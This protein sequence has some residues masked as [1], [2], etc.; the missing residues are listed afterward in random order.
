MTNPIDVADNPERLLSRRKFCNEIGISLSTYAKLKR[1]G[2]GPREMRFPGMTLVLITPEAQRDW[3]RQQEKW[4]AS[5]A[6]RLEEERRK[7]LMSAAGKKGVASDRHVSKRGKRAA[8]AAAKP[9]RR[10]AR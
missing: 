1:E 8:E 9:V 4:S 6:A 5:N 7:A 3:I 10:A 2:R